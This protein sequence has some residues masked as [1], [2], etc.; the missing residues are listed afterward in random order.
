MCLS[1]AL[2][3]EGVGLYLLSHQNEQ[4]PTYLRWGCI[5]TYM[6]TIQYRVHGGKKLSLLGV[7][8]LREREK[9]PLEQCFSRV[10][11]NINNA[12]VPAR[13]HLLSF[14]DPHRHALQDGML[15]SRSSIFLASP[16][17]LPYRVLAGQ[18]EPW[19]P[20]PPS[21]NPLPSS[22]WPTWLPPPRAPT[23]SFCFAICFSEYGTL[24]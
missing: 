6:H 3:E 4:R 24:L 21:Q 23:R 18:R 16:L 1:Q 12:G 17:P 13:L 20:F 15:C 7:G 9:S 8:F 22:P 10:S 11:H 5:H 2:P 14:R 19:S